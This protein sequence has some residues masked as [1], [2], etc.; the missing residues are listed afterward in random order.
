[1]MTYTADYPDTV[2][3]VLSDEIKYKRGVVSAVKAYAEAGA[4]TGDRN[5]RIAK[6]QCILQCLSEIYEIPCPSL[7]FRPAQ[8][9]NGEYYPA[10]NSITLHGKLSVLTLLH[11]FAHALGKGERGACR[12]S[13]NL[14]RR[15]F[16]EQYTR[17]I[18]EGHTLRRGGV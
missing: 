2:A 6:M 10:Q 17:L 4:W 18:P 11:E 16:L 14:F 3:E 9:S 1:M 12:W 8:V 7:T 13:I 5:A 15:C